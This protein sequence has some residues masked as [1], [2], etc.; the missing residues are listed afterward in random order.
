MATTS[1]ATLRQLLAYAVGFYYSG[2]NTGTANNTVVDTELQ[3]WDTGRLVNRWVLMTAGN[4]DGNSRR[5]ASVSTS[6]ATVSPAWGAA[7][8]NTDTFEILPFDP[9]IIHYALREACRTVWPKRLN[10]RAPRGLYLPVTDETLVV[11]NLIATNHDFESAVAAGDSPG[12]TKENNPTLADDT[13]ARMHGSQGLKVTAGASVG[14]LYQSLGE[15]YKIAEM[16]GKTVV[17]RPWAYAV[18]A[19]TARAG[20]S[21]DGGTTFTYSSYHGGAT[22]FEELP[23]A[24]AIPTG[25]VGVS[26]WLEVAASGVVTFDLAR[27]WIDRVTQYTIPTSLYPNGPYKVGQ[28]IYSDRPDGPYAPLRGA[29]A[30]RI[31][32]LEGMGRLAVPTT[33]SGTTEVDEVEAELLIA[34]AAMHMFRVLANTERELRGEHNEESQRW[35]V[36]ANEARYSVGHLGM[37]ADERAFW[38]VG[39]E[40][41][42]TLHLDR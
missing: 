29:T 20:I 4:N 1:R 10:G 23:V 9:D 27:A 5:I 21:F 7:N 28:Q 24:A 35:E 26:V 42:R 15:A 38:H 19:S 36:K 40:S 16:V 8:A 41:S 32:R 12:W 18:A 25:A 13:A 34:E 6:T 33:D 39:N 3:R 31:L 14:R 37:G 2:T 30:G 17:F 22:E 11:D